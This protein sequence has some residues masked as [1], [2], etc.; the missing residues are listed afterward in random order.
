MVYAAC[1]ASPSPP[2]PTVGAGSSQRED[3]PARTPQQPQRAQTVHASRHHAPNLPPRLSPY[4]PL[5]IPPPSPYHRRTIVAAP[6]DFAVKSEGAAALVLRMYGA[7]TAQVRGRWVRAYGVAWFTHTAAEGRAR[8]YGGRAFV[9]TWRAAS[10]IDIPAMPTVG[11]GSSRFSRRFPR[12]PP[13][14]CKPP[15]PSDSPCAEI[16]PCPSR[17][18]PYLCPKFTTTHEGRQHPRGRVPR[19][20]P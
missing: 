2:T 5:T 15:R 7:Y 20:H 9:A 6:S 3:S 17:F 12:P 16:P 13:P 11:A 1:V 8:A 4:Q 18:Y 10:R 14:P 19:C